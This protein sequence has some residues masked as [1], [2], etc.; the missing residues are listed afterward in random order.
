M[1]FYLFS[2]IFIFDDESFFEMI[3]AVCPGP[4]SPDNGGTGACCVW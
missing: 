2:L 1:L 4:P 3:R